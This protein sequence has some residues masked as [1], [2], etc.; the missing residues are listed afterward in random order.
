MKPSTTK[1]AIVYS[2]WGLFTV[3]GFF[4]LLLGIVSIFSGPGFE[5]EIVLP[6]VKAEDAV[7][8]IDR[9]VESHPEYQHPWM[10]ELNSADV[11]E[12]RYYRSVYQSSCNQ[13]VYFSIRDTAEGTALYIDGLYKNGTENDLLSVRFV[14][15]PTKTMVPLF[16]FLRFNFLSHYSGEIDDSMFFGMLMWE[17]GM[18]VMPE[19]L[20]FMLALLFLI[21]YWQYRKWQLMI[22]SMFCIGMIFSFCEMDISVLKTIGGDI[23]STMWLLR[24]LLGVI[25][26]QNV[27]E[28]SMMYDYMWVVNLIFWALMPLYAYDISRSTRITVSVAQGLLL[29]FAGSFAVCPG[30]VYAYWLGN[31]MVVP[32]FD[33][34]LGYWIWMLCMFTTLIIY[35]CDIDAPS[36]IDDGEDTEYLPDQA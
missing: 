35:I 24:G 10:E 6:G 36:R 17:Y 27:S 26:Y 11:P 16:L 32:I 13:V 22:M 2:V 31:E 30:E 23:P 4:Y 5:H 34:G 9:I 8:E 20:S 19:Y 25:F 15:R 1:L 28:W 7:Q 18:K 33:M 21:L 29:L 12:N 3:V 14:Y